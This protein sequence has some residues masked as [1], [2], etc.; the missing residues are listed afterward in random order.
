[1]NRMKDS[2]YKAVLS[3]SGLD[4]RPYYLIVRT[5]T[6]SGGKIGAPAATGQAKSTDSDLRLPQ[7]FLVR[8]MT[9]REI[10]GSGGRYSAGDV[11]VEHIVPPGDGGAGFSIAQLNPRPT[12]SGIEIIYVIAGTTDGLSGEYELVEGKFDKPMKY[13]LVLRRKRT[14]P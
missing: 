13:A 14:T 2:V 3:P 7:Y 6:Y 9:T 8:E 12:A 11:T 10:A 4:Q 1:M 5:R